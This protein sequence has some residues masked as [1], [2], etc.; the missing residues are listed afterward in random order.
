MKGATN[1]GKTNCSKIEEGGL[2][3][4]SHFN[5]ITGRKTSHLWSNTDLTQNTQELVK[6][7]LWFGSSWSYG[8]SAP[9]SY[10]MWDCPGKNENPGRSTNFAFS[11]TLSSVRGYELDIPKMHH[12]GDYAEYIHLLFVF[13]ADLLHSALNAWITSKVIQVD[14]VQ[15]S[16][17][18]V[19]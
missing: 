13:Q 10:G 4:G 11:F 1:G 18:L 8:G 14:I 5:K 16:V 3:F 7:V 2:E 19:L 6:L 9:I 17:L 12:S 15:A